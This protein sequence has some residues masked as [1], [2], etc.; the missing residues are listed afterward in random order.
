MGGGAGSGSVSSSFVSFSS[1]SVHGGPAKVVR[2]STVRHADG[3][4]ETTRHEGTVP[5]RQGLSGIDMQLGGLGLGM[6]LFDD[7]FFQEVGLG[8]RGSRGAPLDRGSSLG[9]LSFF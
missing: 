7:P 6:S 9:R 3:S 4:V 1:R 5:A 2:V 8:M